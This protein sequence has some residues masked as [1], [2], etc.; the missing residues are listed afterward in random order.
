MSERSMSVRVPEVLVR[1]VRE[2]AKNARLSV[3]KTLDWLVRNSL[4]N[5]QALDGLADCPEELTSKLDIRIPV[6]TFEQLRAASQTFRISIS[7]Y[8]RVLLY[9]F[10]VTK[11]VFYVK[12]GDRYTLAAKD[13]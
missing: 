2:S 3:S 8:T 5:T 6:Q 4:S 1:M 11:R 7:V 10:Y 9:H 12:S 13:H